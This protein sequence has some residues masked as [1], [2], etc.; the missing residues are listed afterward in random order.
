MLGV[1]VELEVI[2]VLEQVVLEPAP[3]L[4][5]PQSLIG[6]LAAGDLC[7]R[8]EPHDGGH[9]QGAAA[10]AALVAAAVDDRGDAHAG[11]AAHPQ[12]ADALGAVELVGADGDQ[13]DLHLLDVEGQFPDALHRVAVEEDALPLHHRADLGDGLDGSDLVVREH[14]GNQD[15]LVGDRVADL[16]RG[17]PAVLVDLE[18]GDLEALALEPLAGVQ[19]RLVLGPGGDDV[20]ALLLVELGHSL[21]GE[22]VRLGGAGAEDDLLLVASRAFCTASSAFQPY[23]WL[24]LAALPNSVVR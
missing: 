5:G 3:Q 9:V 1:A 13:V 10:H 2:E 14:D 21:D 15:G 7:R 11:L 4:A 12:R 8:A 18:V 23:A 6:H 20:V 19:D 17:H 22:V 24:R 16:L